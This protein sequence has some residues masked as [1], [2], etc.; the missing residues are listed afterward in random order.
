MWGPDLGRIPNGY[1]CSLHFLVKGLKVEGTTMC[2][3]VSRY[4]SP[5]TGECVCVCY[6]V[7]LLTDIGKSL[8]SRGQFL[9][10][11]D[12]GCPDPHPSP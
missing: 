12:L 2:D 1:Q 10:S 6:F 4:Y 8:R 11:V 9:T 3:W 7:L 5:A